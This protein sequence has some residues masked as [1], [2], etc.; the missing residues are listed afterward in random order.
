MQTNI[1]KKMLPYLLSAVLLYYGVPAFAVGTTGDWGMT[2]MVLGLLGINTL[3][4]FFSSFLFTLRNGFRW[5]YPVL[6]GVLFV[7][8]IT[9]FYNSSATV[10]VFIYMLLAAAGSGLAVLIKHLVQNKK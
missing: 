5:Y 8:I 2:L 10:Y 1:M 6:L 4:C 3:F 7:P 9:T